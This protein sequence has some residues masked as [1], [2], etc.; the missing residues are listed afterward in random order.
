[1]K[2]GPI[3]SA[4]GNT[5]PSSVSERRN[6]QAGGVSSPDEASAKVEL[7]STA[8]GA[9]EDASF[10]KAKVERIATAIREGRF[11]VDAGAIAD[12]LIANAQEVLGRMKN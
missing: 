11:Q 3:E 12:K 2:I 1:M 4:K 6:G 8:L 7:S 10:D 5:G 9:S